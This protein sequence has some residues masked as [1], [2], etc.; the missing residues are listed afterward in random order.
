MSKQSVQ[1]IARHV[2]DT[3]FEH[4][5]RASFDYDR[6]QA[7]LRPL[8]LVH[9]SVKRP[10]SL[11]SST[12]SRDVASN[13]CQALPEP[14]LDEPPSRR[15]LNSS[16]RQLNVSNFCPIWWGALLVS[17]TKTAQ[18]EQRCGRVCALAPAPL[19]LLVLVPVPLR[20]PRAAAAA[21][22]AVPA[23]PASAAAAAAAA[24]LGFGLCE[25]CCSGRG[26]GR[27]R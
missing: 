6:P 11:L 4:S 27:W 18:V 15:G 12:A 22:A 24:T 5:L 21:A 10:P 2:I 25:C 17:V 13:R 7:F 8:A 3:H 14:L 9:R 23:R 26:M 16:N 1:N 19:P 20:A